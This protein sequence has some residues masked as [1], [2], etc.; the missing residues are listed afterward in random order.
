MRP[1]RLTTELTGRVVVDAISQHEPF[2]IRISR[3]GLAHC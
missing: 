2:D 3:S 1:Q